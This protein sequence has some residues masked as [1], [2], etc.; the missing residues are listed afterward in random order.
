MTE[1]IRIVNLTRGTLLGSRIALA[2]GWWARLRG[3][4]GR[5]R[6]RRGEGILLAPCNAVHTYGMTFDLDLV[7]LDN[8][9]EVLAVVEELEPWKKSGRI[10]RSRYALEVPAGTVRATGTN[11]GDTFAWTP[12]NSSLRSTREFA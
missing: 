6:P 7:F 1:H 5:E 11:V 2:D 12:A 8:A 9:G 3:F 4:L 10:R